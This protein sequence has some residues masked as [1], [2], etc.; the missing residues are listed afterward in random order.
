MLIVR[1]KCFLNG[2][3]AAKEDLI[4]LNRCPHKIFIN[5]LFEFDLNSLQ[6]LNNK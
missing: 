3:N 2:N 4:L 6:N 5:K 1:I